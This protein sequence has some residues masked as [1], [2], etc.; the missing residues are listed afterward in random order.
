MDIKKMDAKTDC[1]LN[2]LHGNNLL[3]HVF[4]T[5]ASET[6]RPQIENPNENFQ[7]SLA[8]F[9]HASYISTYLI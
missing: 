3:L 2:F 6:V 4:I 5:S 1:L 9:N 7:Y 8:P